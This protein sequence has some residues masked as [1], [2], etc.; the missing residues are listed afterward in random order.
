MACVADAVPPSHSPEQP[1]HRDFNPGNL[2]WSRNRWTGTVDWVHLCRGP[3]EEDLAR[4][5]LNIWLLA[6]VPAAARFLEVVES[7]GVPYD[8]RWDLS[9]LADAA[10]H[11]DGFAPAANQLGAE[12]TTALVRARAQDIA[13][14]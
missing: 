3:V 13:R 10:H 2:L 9:L 1:I 12:L 6:G 14:Q 5:R 11:L 7:S 4:C 8:R